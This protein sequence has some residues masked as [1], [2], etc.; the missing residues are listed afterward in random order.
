MDK[1]IIIQELSNKLSIHGD[2][3]MNCLNYVSDEMDI[4]IQQIIQIIYSY[5]LNKDISSVYLLLYY[6]KSQQILP[7]D[8]TSQ[9][10]IINSYLS[11][12]ESQNLYDMCENILSD[13]DSEYHL[14][15]KPPVMVF[16]RECR[17]QRDVGFYSNDSEGYKYS[18]KTA[19][20]KPLPDFLARMMTQINDEFNTNFNG[21][22]VNKYNDGSE[23][24][25][26]HSDD[27][28]S[29]S[30]GGI[31]ISI[32]LGS[33]RIFRIRDKKTK[34]VIVD[35]ETINGQL[36]AMCGE[37]QKHYTHEIPCQKRIKMTRYS[38]TFRSH[39]I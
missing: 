8:E 17:Q 34:R 29:L 30:K 18:G 25:G 38:L 32:T 14:D 7:N 1:H 6:P 3:I 33:S 2:D 22:L 5:Y 23:S 13:P 16:G 31:V 19:R 24:I 11:Q 21:I 35:V 4:S 15:I 28:R 27:E 39:I 20:S 36:L 9:L 10:I 26:A 37:F 12:D